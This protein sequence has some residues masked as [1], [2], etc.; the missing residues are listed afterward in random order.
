VPEHRATAHGHGRREGMGLSAWTLKVELGG[1]CGCGCGQW[2]ITLSLSGLARLVSFVAAFPGGVWLAPAAS[3]FL[4]AALSTQL[5]HPCIPPI[6]PPFAL[7]FACGHLK[8][9]AST[10]PRLKNR[11]AAS[12]PTDAPDPTCQRFGCGVRSLATLLMQALA[13]PLIAHYHAWT[14]FLSL[15]HA[16]N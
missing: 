8:S 12:E 11:H 1:G 4:L 16:R 7:N 3:C 6:P 9:Q 13:K 10:S 15:H 2:M 14:D 5:L